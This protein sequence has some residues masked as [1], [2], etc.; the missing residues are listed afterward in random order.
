MVEKSFEIAVPVSVGGGT[1]SGYDWEADK[2]RRIK[3]M[4]E[5]YES[6]PVKLAIALVE[7]VEDVY[8]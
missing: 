7:S 4:L 5:K 6:D 8:D 1:C 3:E 2:Q